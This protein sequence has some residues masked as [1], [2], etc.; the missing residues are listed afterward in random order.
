MAK[1]SYVVW[2]LCFVLL[3]ACS[4]PRSYV[5]LLESPDGTPGAV[6]VTG[7]QGSSRTLNKVGYASGLDGTTEEAFRLDGK[8]LEQVFGAAMAARPEA[9]L[10]FV[11]YFKSDKT[12]LTAESA[13][14]IPG[15]I[16]AIARRAAPDIGIVGHSDSYGDE[17][18]NHRL[19]LRRARAIKKAIIE[20]GVDAS[21]MEVTSHGENNPLVRTAD[22][23]REPRNRRVEVTVR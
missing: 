8:Q 10:T 22:N 7:P 18:Y 14:E 6:T 1:R 9:A 4:Q 23:V 20:A 15:I 13:G 16:D 5:V 19:A 21:A 2:L 11:L 17:G 12:D 3:G